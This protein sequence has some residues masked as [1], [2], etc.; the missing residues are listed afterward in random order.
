MFSLIMVY[1]DEMKN[2][3]I[4]LDSYIV[5]KDM[6]IRLPKEILTIFN[7]TKGSSFLDIYIDTENSA[8]L[9]KPASD[10]EDNKDEK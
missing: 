10:R 7:L 8:I 6:R 2:N 1:G 9:L 5:Q 4:Y 3:K